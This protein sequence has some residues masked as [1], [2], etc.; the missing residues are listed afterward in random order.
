MDVFGL[1][2]YIIATTNFLKGMGGLGMALGTY[3][4]YMEF[5]DP[6]NW[7]VQDYKGLA[8]FVLAIINLFF[9]LYYTD[10]FKNIKK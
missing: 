1:C 9:I 4:F 8:T 10:L 6:M 7:R 5:N 3:F 2:L